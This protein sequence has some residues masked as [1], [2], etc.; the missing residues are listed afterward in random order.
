MPVGLGL[1]AT[2]GTYS[3]GAA[4]MLRNTVQD[5]L[6]RWNVTT[7]IGI[8][9]ALSALTSPAGLALASATA[10]AASELID[11]SVYTPLRARG[12]G[13]A[14]LAASLVGALLDTTL[15]LAIS[16]LPFTPGGVAGQLLGKLWAVWLPTAAV[17]LWRRGRGRAAC[18]T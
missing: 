7:A 4:L 17:L 5:Q 15:F 9:G 6:G 16:G 13:R 11:T 1:T 3:A 8:G 2:A 12:W 14:V 10:F 18:A